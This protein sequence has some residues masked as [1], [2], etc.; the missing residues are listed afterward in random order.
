MTGIQVVSA[1][2]RPSREEQIEQL[3]ALVDQSGAVKVRVLVQLYDEGKQQY[4]GLRDAQ[5]TLTIAKPSLRPGMVEGMVGALG[6]ALKRIGEH[7]HEAVMQT[8]EGF[9]A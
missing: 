1:D 3:C 8:L 2:D 4:A 5:W 9:E 7:G 6:W